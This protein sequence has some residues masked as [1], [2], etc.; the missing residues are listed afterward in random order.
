MGLERREG[1]GDGKGEK[2]RD[3]GDWKKGEW[4]GT[5]EGVW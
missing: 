1:V 5:S 3:V 2:G 4:W